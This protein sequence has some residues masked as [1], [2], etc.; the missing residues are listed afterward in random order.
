MKIISLKAENIK[1]LVAVEIKPDGNMVEITGK[2][3]H[4]KT[5]VLDSIWWALAGSSNVQSVPIRTGETK[6]KIRLDMGELVVTRTF[7]SGKENES[8]SSIFVEN[9]DGARFPS[10]QSV[11]DK[12]IGELSF[13]PL[14]FA[15]M[16][17]KG[18][19]DTLRRFVPGVDFDGI[20]NKN[21]A[22][23]ETRKGLNRKA[24]ENRAAAEL[25]HFDHGLVNDHVNDKEIEDEEVLMNEFEVAAE[26]N[27]EIEKQFNDRAYAL[28]RAED[29]D[30]RVEAIKV[31]IQKLEEE[32][33]EV[34]EEGLEN[35]K[36]GRLKIQKPIDLSEFRQKIDYSKA[37][38]QA[39]KKKVEQD[40]Y[41][42]EAVQLET[43]ALEIT[44]RMNQREEEKREK[45]S[46][47][48]LPIPEISFGDN[49]IMMNG[50]PFDQASDAEQL[51]ASLAIAMSLNPK[52]R[53][54]RVRDGSLL[55]EDSMAIVSKM[56]KDKDFQVW[57]E[58]V[59]GSGKVGFVLEDGMLKTKIGRKV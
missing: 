13:D 44:R 53:V 1:K 54:I 28:E 59:D 35:E 36:I 23:Y 32:R 8:T 27:T 11:L 47:A 39:F 46:S 33:K 50:V 10:P 26:K 15:R 3:G 9:A 20:E 41:I 17:P 56:A 57:I 6:A 42:G 30:E 18:Q 58:K 55:D 34:Y 43:N 37:V 48:K 25:V 16:S 52:L 38:G 14:G 40:N 21:R 12:L 7:K 2:N 4:G 24:K 31:E 45:I 22:D 5:S 51:R 29:C 19:F 49:I